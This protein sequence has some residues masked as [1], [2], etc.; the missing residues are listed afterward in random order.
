MTKLLEDAIAAVRRLPPDRQDE[1]A[2]ALLDFADDGGGVYVLTPEE[3]A[4]IEESKD[5]A[6]RGAFATDEEVRAIWAKHG[7]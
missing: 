1:I 4:A 6:G 5:A 2:R 7:L 3:R